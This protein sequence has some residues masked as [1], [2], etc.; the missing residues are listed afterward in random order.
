MKISASDNRRSSARSSRRE[1]IGR[2]P[3]CANASRRG[4][5]ARRRDTYPVPTRYR[6]LV[7]GVAPLQPEQ[8]NTGWYRRKGCKVA[9]QH[10]R[11][12][13][14]DGWR[15]V[16]AVQH[17]RVGVEGQRS[18]RSSSAGARRCENSHA[19]SPPRRAF[20]SWQEQLCVA[21]S[22]PSPAE[23]GE[24]DAGE[25]PPRNSNTF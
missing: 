7:A 10:Y 12:G 3:V 22:S 24:Q 15:G 9:A 18:S 14:A 19:A 1:S 5:A 2:T 11:H 8:H 16:A 4:E 23:E 21:P 6:Y 13:E 25:A 20:L 17:C